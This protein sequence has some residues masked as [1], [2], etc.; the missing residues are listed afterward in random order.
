MTEKEKMLSGNLYI[1]HG[2]ELRNDMLRA[3]KI[4]RLFN[5]TTE[6]ETEYRVKLLKELF[7]KTGEK[8]HIEPPFY[9]DYG[10]NITVGESFYANFDCIILDVNKVNIGN[11]VFFG[12]RV[13]IYTAGHPID[14]DVRNTLLEYGKPIKIG[15]NVWIGGNTIIN[16]GITVGNNVVIGSGSIITKDIPENVIAVGNPCKVLRLITEEDK[17]HWEDKKIG[18]FDRAI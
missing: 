18:D 17:K 12:P 4:T 5:G 7:G 8:I 11:N 10:Y 9:C 6:L 2:D 15:N 14:A 3:R 16:P 13:C 1:L